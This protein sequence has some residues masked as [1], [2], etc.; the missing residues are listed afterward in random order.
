M[1]RSSSWRITVV[2][3]GRRQAEGGVDLGQVDSPLAERLGESVE[4]PTRWFAHG[5]QSCR[6]SRAGG[7]RCRSPTSGRPARSRRPRGQV[8]AGRGARLRRRTVRRHRPRSRPPRQA[9]R[10]TR[11][12]CQPHAP[13]DR[14]SARP[15]ARC[16]SGPPSGPPVRVRAGRRGA[17]IVADATYRIG[18]VAGPAVAFGFV[19][20]MRGA[21]RTRDRYRP[22]SQGRLICEATYGPRDC[23]PV[24]GE[25]GEQ[26]AHPPSAD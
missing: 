5:P 7:L 19:P 1:T 10:C 9:G 26:Q 14:G 13:D 4:C 25:P 8:S 11:A 20:L 3:H 22:R 24:E 17:T 2:G 12:S 21:H 18:Q 15:A 23:Q 16:G 6:P